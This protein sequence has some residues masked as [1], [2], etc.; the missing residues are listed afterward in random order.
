MSDFTYDSYDSSAVKVAFEHLR[1]TEEKGFWFGV[2][3]GLPAGALYVYNIRKI[4]R[5]PV[6]W[7]LT[8]SI[9]LL[10]GSAM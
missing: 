3:V 2:L 1:Q 8:A 10:T 5:L 4:S 7:A 9:P 6:P